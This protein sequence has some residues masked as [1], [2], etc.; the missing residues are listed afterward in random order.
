MGRGWFGVVKFRIAKFIQPEK[1][2][3][4][5]AVLVAISIPIFT[6][7]LEKSRDAVDMANVR[8]AYAEAA[9]AYLTDQDSSTDMTY[10][11]TIAGKSTDDKW[12][13]TNATTAKI[14]DVDVTMVKQAK[15]VQIKFTGTTGK[16]E[17]TMLTAAPSKEG[18]Q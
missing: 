9:S 7:Q 8:A 5:R 14:A 6:A 16:Y 15:G 3:G 1:N 11:Y 18:K 12:A 13:Q 4:D 17:I 2:C 10:A